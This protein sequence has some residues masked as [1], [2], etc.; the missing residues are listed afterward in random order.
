MENREFTEFLDGRKEEIKEENKQMKNENRELRKAKVKK[1]FVALKKGATKV[2]LSPYLAVKEI[3]KYH[4]KK[5]LERQNSLNEKRT[6]QLEKER[7]MNSL[8]ARFNSTKIGTK[9][10]KTKKSREE[11]HYITDTETIVNTQNGPIS[12][13]HRLDHE[14]DPNPYNGYEGFTE[15]GTLRGFVQLN[16]PESPIVYCEVTNV[17]DYGAYDKRIPKGAF[18][19]CYLKNGKFVELENP[20][21]IFETM[22]GIYQTAE[23]NAVLSTDSPSD[24]IEK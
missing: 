5:K 13:T 11:N 16:G 14:I 22:Y 8:I 1:F 9:T 4:N 7:E 21:A 19:G 3:K 18:E 23:K 12:F 20:Q 10:I 15:K 2:V 6:Y 24:S 17:K